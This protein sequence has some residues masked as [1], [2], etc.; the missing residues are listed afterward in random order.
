LKKIILVTIS[1][2]C[3]Q[4]FAK[5]ESGDT[6]GAIQTLM[7]SIHSS[8]EYALHPEKEIGTGDKADPIYR[9][10]FE[11]TL[12]ANL[13]TAVGYAFAANINFSYYTT[14]TLP[15]D[16]RRYLKEE[17]RMLIDTVADVRNS[18]CGGNAEI[19][20]VQSKVMAGNNIATNVADYIETNLNR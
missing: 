2:F 7:S 9:A 4:S 10:K 12:C 1:L 17:I 6:L 16:A 13:G 14:A 19:G 3:A 20:E 15:V 8:L 11:K 18:F 5:S